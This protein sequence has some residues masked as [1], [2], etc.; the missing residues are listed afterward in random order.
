M[1][2][3]WPMHSVGWTSSALPLMSPSTLPS[4][5]ART[6]APHPRHFTASISGCR[7]AGSISP[8]SI[9]SPCA[10]T[11]CFSARLREP[12]DEPDDGER[13]YI[14]GDDGIDWHVLRQPRKAESRSETGSLPCNCGKMTDARCRMLT[15]CGGGPTQGKRGPSLRR[16]FRDEGTRHQISP[17][18]SQAKPARSRDAHECS[19]NGRT[20][21]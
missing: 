21:A 12:I 11:L 7:E 19:D 15:E 17:C 10:A 6:Q 1:Q 20:P 9:N 13:S 8:A 4:G 5:Q 2:A 16:D 18:R 3:P 14:G